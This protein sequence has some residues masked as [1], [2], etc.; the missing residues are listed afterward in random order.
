VKVCKADEEAPK[1]FLVK[2]NKGIFSCSTDKLYIIDGVYVDQ[3]HPTRN[4]FG[5][6]LD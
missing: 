6:E 3:T 1:K 5:K 4:E 2:K